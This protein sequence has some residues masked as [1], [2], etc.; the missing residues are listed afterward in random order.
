MITLMTA[1]ALAAAQAAPATPAPGSH[2]QHSQSG[3][4]NHS[5]MDHSKMDHSKMSQHGGGCCVRAADGTMKCAMRSNG[6]TSG[7]QQGHSGH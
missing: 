7:S 6:G 1:A 2:A 5:Q 4:T 3:Q